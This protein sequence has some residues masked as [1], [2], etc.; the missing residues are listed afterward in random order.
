MKWTMTFHTGQQQANWKHQAAIQ[1]SDVTQQFPINFS[2]QNTNINI[3]DQK[4]NP[5]YHHLSYDSAFDK[6][7]ALITLRV[8]MM[9]VEF[10]QY[11]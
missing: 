9:Q 1:N 3:S 7:L 5:I 6:F 11:N 10:L 4:K 2:Q 8:V